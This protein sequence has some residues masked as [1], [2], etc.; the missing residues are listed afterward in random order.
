MWFRIAVPVSGCAMLFAAAAAFAQSPSNADKQFMT[1]AARTNMI[2]AHEGQMAEDQGAPDIKDFAQTLV[3]DHTKAYQDLQQ[4]ASKTG[5]Q[6][7]TGIDSG[8]DPAIRQLMHLK[9]EGFDRQFARDEVVDHQRAIAAFRR[10]ADH[11]QDP[12]VKNYA[13]Q[14]IPILQK[15]LQMAQEIAKPAK[16]S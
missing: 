4:L 13:S 3:T 16:K 7:P 1:M 8:K 5:V 14:M 12:D 9:G 11:G 15:H 2:E 6:I 10:E